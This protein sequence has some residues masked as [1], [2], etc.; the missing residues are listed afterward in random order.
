MIVFVFAL[1]LLAAAGAEQS[2]QTGPEFPNG[3][4]RFGVAAAGVVLAGLPPVSSP[5]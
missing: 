5:A 2:N 4:L 3:A 1:C